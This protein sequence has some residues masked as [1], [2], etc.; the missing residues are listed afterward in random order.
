MHG[1][2]NVKFLSE[3]YK[4]IIYLSV[5]FSATYITFIFL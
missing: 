4:I 1:S 5:Y 2:L 3:Y